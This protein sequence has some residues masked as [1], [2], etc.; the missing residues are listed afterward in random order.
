ML[1]N[2]E[3]LS[4]FQFLHD[5]Y[6]IYSVR[7]SIIVLFNFKSLKFRDKRKAIFSFVFS[8][9]NELSHLKTEFKHFG[10][11]RTKKGAWVIFNMNKI[12]PYNNI[13][14]IIR[15]SIILVYS[16]ALPNPGVSQLTYIFRKKTQ[17]CHNAHIFLGKQLLR[18]KLSEEIKYLPQTLIF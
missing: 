4:F 15:L 17:G 8:V 7:N 13:I 10:Q 11:K 6:I 18:I 9:I 14:I 3:E 16:I 2:L 5:G 1:C 12:S